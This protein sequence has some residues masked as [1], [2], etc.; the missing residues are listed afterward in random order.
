M[1]KGKTWSSRECVFLAKC[2][3]ATSEDASVGADTK[4]ET[5]WSSVHSKWQDQT[6]DKT[7]TLQALKN[8]SVVM[9]RSVQKF[10]GYHERVQRT[11]QSGYTEED[12]VEAAITMYMNIENEEFV[13]AEPWRVLVVSPKWKPVRRGKR[14]SLGNDPTCKIDASNEQ[15]EHPRGSK[16]AKL[17]NKSAKD[18]NGGLVM[19]G[20]AQIEKNNLFRQSM[21]IKLLTQSNDIENLE[22]VKQQLLRETLGGNLDTAILNEKTKTTSNDFACDI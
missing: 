20:N 1:G 18:Q 16:S 12:A 5:F 19:I 13:Y 22:R 11:D 3:L 21:L 9:Q 10:C 7:R 2:W 6:S 15:E 14:A 17:Y 4:L 8:Q